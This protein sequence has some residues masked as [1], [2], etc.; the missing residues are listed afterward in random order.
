[1]NSVRTLLKD[2]VPPVALRTL[3]QMRGGAI[4]FEGDFASWDEAAAKCPGYDA[5]HILAKVLDATLKVK[6]GEAAFERDSVL[7]DEIEYAWPMLTGLMW[8]T[9]RNGG[10]LN[11]LDFGGALGSSYFQNRPFLQSLPRVRWNVVEQAH[12]VQAGQEHIQDEHL[13]FY[14]TIDACLA[15]SQPNVVLLSSVLQYLSNV[16]ECIDKLNSIGSLLIII[17]RTIINET[18]GDRVYIQR[19]S[20]SIYHASYPC[21]SLSQGRLISRFANAY[22]LT[23]SF[24]SLQFPALESIESKFKGF[25]FTRKFDL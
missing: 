5:E 2:W 21:R 16:D 8:A 9:A 13:R 10:V 4:R 3:R 17:D 25:I 11:V 1:M 20:P 24:Q 12:Y 7:F 19:V 22:D 18:N 15:E 6:R 23:S 14:P